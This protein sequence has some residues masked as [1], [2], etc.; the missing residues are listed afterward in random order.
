MILRK[1][2]LFI[3]FSGATSIN[4][5]ELLEPSNVVRTENKPENIVTVPKSINIHL[6]YAIDNEKRNWGLMQRQSLPN[7]YGML[8]SNP[9]K[10][11]MSLWSFN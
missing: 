8:F 1:F 9:S 2:L 4:A 10:S 7:N 5:V 11:T 6:D 3:L